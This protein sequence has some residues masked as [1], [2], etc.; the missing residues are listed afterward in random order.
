MKCLRAVGFLVGLSAAVSFA[1]NQAIYGDALQNGWQSYG[2]ATLNYANGS[3]VHGGTK[4]VSVSAAAYEAIYLHHAAFDPAPYNALRFWINGGTT[5]GQTF[6]VRATVNGNPQTIY[7]LGPISANTWTQVVIPLSTLGVATNTSFDG[8]WIQD[9]TGT[10][11]PTW[12]VDDIDLV[13]KP[14]PPTP[15]IQIDA[16]H[17]LQTIDTRMFAVAAAVWDNVFN[18]PTT[19]QYFLA[20]G[21]T[22]SRFPGGSLSDSYHWQTGR[23]D[24]NTLWATN[25]D[26]FAN[27]MTQANCNAFITV[28]YGSGTSD[29][30]AAWVQYS[31]VTKH[32]NFKYWEI[33]NE[34]YGSW[35]ND[36]HAR[37][38]D[39]YTYAQEAANY[40]AVMKSVDPTIKIGV[41]ANPGEDTYANFTDHPATN[42]RT[43]TQHNGW[44]A[45]M[46]QTLR[47]LGVTPDFIIHHRY[48]QSPGAES[49][50]SLLQASATWPNDVNDLRQ[51]LSD[52]MGVAGAN[53]QIICTE[54]NSVYT[55]PGKQTTS[56]VNGL[57]LCD[58]LGQ[59]MKTE[60]KGLSWWIFRNGQE[61]TNNNSSS[62][63]GWRAYGDYGMVSGSNDRYP[64][65][66]ASRLIQYFARA[67]DKSLT[68]SSNYALLSGYGTYRQ[69]GTLRV[70]VINKDPNAS[71]T[72]SVT[73]YGLAPASGATVYTYGIPQDNAAHTGSGSPDIA[74]TTISNAAP[75]FTYTFPPY[76][77]T[78]FVL[79]RGIVQ[80]P[81]R[82]P[83]APSGLTATAL[84]QN[85]IDLAWTDNAYNETG[86][87]VERS[88][89]NVNFTQIATLPAN[90]WSYPSIGLTANTTYYYRVRAY[91]T[92]APSAFSNT[93]TTKSLPR[94]GGKNPKG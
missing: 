19:I 87:Y 37:K 76:S 29:E 41:V 56:L 82:N 35:E 33:G 6:N 92:I 49:D 65:Y 66:Y 14:A 34:C 1:Q 71:H 57:F 58:S 18:T 43:G 11:K 26:G 88:T 48:E 15:A 53:V 51:Q 31:N 90:A 63:Y 84:S 68:S 50:A 64:A 13:A 47:Q 93:A 74:T 91:N 69:D 72:G 22:T 60:L 79:N 5:G 10:A 78:V 44:T 54:N 32:Y 20:A 8:F 59:A 24:D 52:Y 12:Y 28:N 38:H 42:L 67:G 46:L 80:P 94:I 4:S 73:L 55:N 7:A 75:I 77:V 30:A 70:M 81:P 40:I 3:P 86:F 89:D 27:V 39:P 85:E 45:V 61:N 36:I 62:L 83:D 25:F 21:L 17:P 16:A 23:T 2:W 9:N